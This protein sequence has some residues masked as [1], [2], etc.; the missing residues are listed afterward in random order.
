VENLAQDYEGLAV[1]SGGRN[2]AA[3][4]AAVLCGHTYVPTFLSFILYMCKIWLRCIQN[5]EQLD[6]QGNK[7]RG[8]WGGEVCAIFL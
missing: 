6:W 1:K 4:L 5:R 7:F 8:G 3:I 2:P